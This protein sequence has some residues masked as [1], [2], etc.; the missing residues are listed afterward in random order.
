[1]GTNEYPVIRTSPNQN[2]V[3]IESR[4][5][6]TGLKCF[7]DKFFIIY[8]SKHRKIL[9][10]NFSLNQNTVCFVVTDF[11]FFTELS[12]FLNLFSLL[13]Q[14]RVDVAFNHKEDFRNFLFLNNIFKSSYLI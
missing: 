8:N 6:G 2:K 12:G 14:L 7:L 11:N 5:V 3:Y 13:D 4:L 10:K 1:M 9:L